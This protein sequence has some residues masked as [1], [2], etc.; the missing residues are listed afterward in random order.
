MYNVNMNDMSDIK[1]YT[2]CDTNAAGYGKT[3]SLKAVIETIKNKGHKPIVYRV[4]DGNDLYAQFII[5]SVKIACITQGDPNSHQGEL[6]YESFVWGADV[7]VCAART[8][9]ETFYNIYKT[10]YNGNVADFSAYTKIFLRNPYH[11]YGVTLSQS[12]YNTLG[13]VFSNE[14]IEMIEGLMSI[15]I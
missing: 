8:T 7:I 12:E 11:D 3:T 1:K 13:N 2:I 10:V 15:K 9:G 6:L 5:D 4:I 14:I